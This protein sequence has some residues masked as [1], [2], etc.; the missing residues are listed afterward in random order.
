M[1]A[2]R[3]DRFVW[4]KGDIEIEYPEGYEP[5]DDDD[6]EDDDTGEDLEQ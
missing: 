5:P 1:A 3:T 2:P 6:T 4:E